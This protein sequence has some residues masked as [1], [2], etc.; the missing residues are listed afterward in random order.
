MISQNDLY[1]MSYAL[2]LIRGDID[3]KLN[4]EILTKMKDVLNYKN[5][6]FEDNQIRIA[7]ASISGLNYE[8]WRFVYHNNLYVSHRIL[9]NEKIYDLLI[10]FIQ[11]IVFAMQNK[12]LERSY[13]LVDCFHSLP[14]IIADNNFKVP[15]SYWKNFIYS[16]R[17]KW[18]KKFLK[19]EQ[20]NIV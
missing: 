6:E 18:D 14:I 19:N 2:I 11:E 9:Q 10:K 20:K 17:K 12:N 5:K 8:K 13:N 16:Y 15:R 1:D 3:N 7:L 4:I